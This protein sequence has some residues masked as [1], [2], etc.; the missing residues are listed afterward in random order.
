[1]RARL[2]HLWIYG[3]SD[4][5]L[6]CQG[7]RIGTAEIYRA[8]EKIP[9]V[10]VSLIVRGELP[11][12]NFFMPLFLVLKDGAQLDE[13][14][15]LEITMNLPSTAPQPEQAKAG[16]DTLPLLPSV[17]GHSILASRKAALGVEAAL[18]RQASKDIAAR[19]KPELRAIGS[20]W[21]CSPTD[22]RER[23]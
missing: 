4:S 19:Q 12:G 11:G 23:L 7:V 10:A 13:D 8:V 16:R 20:A 14:L 18:E 21:R 5:T 9:E 2:L 15:Q 17:A 22:T 6:N 1:M 3:R